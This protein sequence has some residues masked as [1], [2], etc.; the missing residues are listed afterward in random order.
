VFP[1]RLDQIRLSFIPALEKPLLDRA[2]TQLSAFDYAEK[3]LRE[4][5]ATYGNSRGETSP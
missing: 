3:L 5:P 1:A 2:N 4:A